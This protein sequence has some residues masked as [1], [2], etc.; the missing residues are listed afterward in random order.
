MIKYKFLNN[1]MDDNTTPTDTTIDT[2]SAEDVRKEQ[3]AAMMIIELER[4]IK[5]YVMGIRSK[6]ET[7]KER[8]QSIKDAVEQDATVQNINLRVQEVK[9]ELKKAQDQIMQT[10]AVQTAREEVKGLKEDIKDM[11][12]NLSKRLLEYR[13]LSHSDQIEL[14]DGILHTI[15]QSAK[16]VRKK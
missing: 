1:P 5:T 2:P 11:Q 16:L 3:D 13:E 12:T 14:D 15:H 6:Q 9:M 4:A 10:T 7:M 8:A